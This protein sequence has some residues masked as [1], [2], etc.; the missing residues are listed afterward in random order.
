MGQRVLMES[1]S[2][3]LL[4][5][6]YQMS[7]LYLKILFKKVNGLATPRLQERI[8]CSFCLSA[9]PIL[10]RTFPLHSQC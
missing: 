6:I 7:F 8:E 4:V 10:S 3:N 2:Y 5:C 1:C 9:L